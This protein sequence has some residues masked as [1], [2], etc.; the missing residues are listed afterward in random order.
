[1]LLE[2][3]RSLEMFNEKDEI[4]DNEF[5]TEE[6]DMPDLRKSP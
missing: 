5:G 4:S 6:A 2:T 3:K 1:L